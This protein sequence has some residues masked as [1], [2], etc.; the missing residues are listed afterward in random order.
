MDLETGWCRQSYHKLRSLGLRYLNNKPPL[1]IPQL[2][3]A[4]AVVVAGGKPEA[5][6]TGW[7]R[8]VQTGI[9]TM[10]IT[11]TVAT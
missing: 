1:I 6:T 8:E 3:G 5:A 10:V 11:P 7:G 2:E 4:G 9:G